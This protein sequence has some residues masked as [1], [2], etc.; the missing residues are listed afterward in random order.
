[1]YKPVRLYLIGMFILLCDSLSKL[2]IYLYL[3]YHAVGYNSEYPYGGIGI[4]HNLLGGIDCT[5]THV[6][7][8]GGAWGVFSTFPRALVIS[9]ILVVSLLFYYILQ[10]SYDFWR[11]LF[12]I[13]IFSGALGNI[14]DYFIYGHVIDMIHF[15]FWGFSLPVFNIADLS[16][17]CGCLGIFIIYLTGKKTA[18]ST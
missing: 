18:T 16:I 5:L 8:P 10:T 4:F 1:M 11:K 9:R 15:S 7:N 6:I 17:C 2:A 12:L 13:T 3:P 14:L